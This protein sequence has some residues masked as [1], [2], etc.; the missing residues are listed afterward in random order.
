MLQAELRQDLQGSV[1][2]REKEDESSTG[3]VWDARFHHVM[4][5]S[6]LTGVLKLTNRL[7]LYFTNFFSGRT[8]PQT[9][10][11]ADTESVDTGSCLYLV[12]AVNTDMMIVTFI[13]GMK[14][15]SHGDLL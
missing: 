3:H 12:G 15:S 14:F 2:A 6:H 13:S 4:A 9:I 5:R 8:E 7:F 1:S 10:E 11:T